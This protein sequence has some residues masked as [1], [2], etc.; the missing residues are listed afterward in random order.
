MFDV[1]ARRGWARLGLASFTGVLG[2]GIGFS[3]IVG[4]CSSDTVSGAVGDA[5]ADGRP[6]GDTDVSAPP[7]DASTG[8]APLV[9]YRS[10]GRLRAEV[11]RAGDAVRF[12]QF[13]D[14][15]RNES[16]SFWETSPGEY[17]CLPLWTVAK[18]ADGTCGTPAVAHLSSCTPDIG[19]AAVTVAPTG[20]TAQRRVAAIHPIGD[21]ADG[22][23]YEKL[24]DG[25]C[26]QVISSEE[27]TRRVLG[28]EV[29]LTEFV[30]ATSVPVNV[31]AEL[32]V[33][34]LFGEDGSELTRDRIID[35]S[36]DAGCGTWVVGAPGAT[37]IA[38][39]PN[40][41]FYAFEESGPWANASCSALAARTFA[42][43]GCSPGAVVVRQ[44]EIDGGA[45]GPRRMSTLHE[46]G[47][48]LTTHYEGA[49]CSASSQPPDVD[50][51]AVGPELPASMFPAIDETLFGAGRVRV[52]AY[53]KAGVELGTSSFYDTMTMR[54][55]VPA[56]FADK[57]V[58]CVPHG[59]RHNVFKD[60]FKDPSCLQRIYL[61]NPCDRVT[62]LIDGN[63]GCGGAGFDVNV[64]PLG[65]PF[66]LATYY[67][68]SATTCD[69]IANDGLVA[70]DVL[71]PVPASEHLVEV[72]RV[73]E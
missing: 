39:V 28:P 35:R 67:V 22:A 21:V 26:T 19:Y 41:P 6:S 1:G 42:P 73:R 50:F 61:D 54:P 4:A 45:C 5:A 47:A 49:E 70:Y 18:Y 43:A 60:R 12:E 32:A 57:K 37:S 56:P 9:A 65:A 44:S 23:T 8:A 20:C 27:A 69:P 38:C 33:E 34:R 25:Q 63:P 13:F 72:V 62:M 36:R 53:A 2:V 55:C 7:S 14:T 48:A 68:K 46:R 11:L 71:P 58:R 29:P 52:M 10:G 3:V 59:A 51:F 17:R 16:C 40:P 66:E 31:T 30:K 24:A 15:K 64:L